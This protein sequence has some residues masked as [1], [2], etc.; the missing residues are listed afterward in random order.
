MTNLS[1]L[2]GESYKNEAFEEGARGVRAC[3]CIP[4]YES[5]PHCI[6]QTSLELEIR[7]PTSAFP[8]LGL[9]ASITLPDLESRLFQMEEFA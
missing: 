6:A 4:Y 8:M 7:P 5:K 2:A 9:Q 1:S 3:M